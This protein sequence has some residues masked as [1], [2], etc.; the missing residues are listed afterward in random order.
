MVRSF[1]RIRTVG[2]QHK[3]IR[4]N[5][6]TPAVLESISTEIWQPQNNSESLCRLYT[7]GFINY[8][9]QSRRFKNKFR[10]SVISLSATPPTPQTLAPQVQNLK[11]P[12][13]S[14]TNLIRQITDVN[15]IRFVKSE[16]DLAESNNK[17]HPKLR[18]ALICK[19]RPSATQRSY[20]VNDFIKQQKHRVRFSS[21]AITV[22]AVM[23]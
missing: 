12:R 9:S 11:Y 2:L 13:Y 15:S 21:H 22:R 7:T 5:S 3:I 23:E 19:R 18:Y 16:T 20:S 4:H 17:P 1:A 10:R 6:T 8:H 14:L